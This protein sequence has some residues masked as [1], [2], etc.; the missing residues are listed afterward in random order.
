[1]IHV[2]DTTIAGISE[3]RNQLPELV[4]QLDNGE[5]IITRRGQPIAVLQSYK[6]FEDMRRAAEEYEN[7]YYLKIALER[8]TKGVKWISE[9]DMEKSLKKRLRKKK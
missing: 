6:S 8:D 4:V 5:V 7:Q 1:M 3:V 2:E 9:E